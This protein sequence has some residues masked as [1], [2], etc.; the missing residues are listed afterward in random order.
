MKFE[1]QQ[2]E[3]FVNL[4]IHLTFFFIYIYTQFDNQVFH[5][6]LQSQCF[7]IANHILDLGYLH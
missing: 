7:S 4:L 3:V 2:I 5:I 1:Y 6:C